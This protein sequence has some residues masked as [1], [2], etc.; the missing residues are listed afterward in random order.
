MIES[1]STLW[2][3]SRT[4]RSSIRGVGFSITELVYQYHINQA[5][6][7]IDRYPATEFE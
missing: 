5:S 3:N 6:G 7:S 4:T 2:V 1:E